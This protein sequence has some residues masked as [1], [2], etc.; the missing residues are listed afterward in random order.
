M[1][2][3]SQAGPGRG[4]EGGSLKQ[5]YNR[6]ATC[7]QLACNYGD[8]PALLRYC[9]GAELGWRLRASSRKTALVRCPQGFASSGSASKILP[10]K[11]RCRGVADFAAPDGRWGYDLEVNWPATCAVVIPCRNEE[12]SIAGL[13]RSVRQYLPKVLVVDDNSGDE[14]AARA[15]EAGAQ[16][17]RRE[18]NPGKGAALKVGVAAALAQNCAWM[19]TL[20]G[21]GQHRPEDIPA[22]LRC[23]EE[24]GASLVIG[25]RMPGAEAI[26]WLRRSV[27]RWMSRQISRIAG[28][29]LPDTQCGFRLINLEGWGAL[30]LETDHY[31][32]ESEMLLAFVQAGCRVEFVPIQVIGRGQR[33]KIHP[34]KDTWRWLRWWK[35]GRSRRR[36]NRQPELDAGEHSA[37]AGARGRNL[38]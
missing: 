38:L 22:F 6:L 1:R 33:S 13:V 31:E 4:G 30:R 26:P 3:R 25:N 24:T 10:A 7:L 8:T 35:G 18:Q 5:A 32:I 37:C 19:M 16:V 20:D 29:F 36:V 12:A 27:N 9:S 23:A 28:K 17:V 15:V 34:V 14:T 11:V 21:D 2:R